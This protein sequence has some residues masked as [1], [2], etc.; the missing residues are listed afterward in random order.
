MTLGE[1]RKITEQYGDDCPLLC[2][3]NVS[4]NLFDT[5]KVDRVL[6]DVLEPCDPQEPWLPKIIVL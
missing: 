5:T 1:F 2:T 3:R 6:I 4:N